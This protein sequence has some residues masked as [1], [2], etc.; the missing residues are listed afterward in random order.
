[1]MDALS[2]ASPLLSALLT[3][4]G[5]VS[6][7]TA[8][9]AVA[10]LALTHPKARLHMW[11]GLL[12]VLLLL[13]V[14]EPWSAPAEQAELTTAGVAA[15]ASFQAA[16]PPRW[17]WSA[18]DWLWALAAGVALRLILVAA[19]FL[20]LRRYRMQATPFAAPPLRFTSNAARWY[21]SDS[22]PGPVT[23]GWRR[24]VILLPAKVLE[25]PADLREAIECHELIHVRRGDWLV[26]LAETL[27]RS[28]L[29]F[30]P[31]IWFVLSRIQLAREQVV[32]CE[33]VG[34]L[35]NRESY[36]NALVAVAGHKLCPNL[37]P[38]P[39]FLRKR[40][41]AARVAAVV[42][43]VDMSRSKILAGVMAAASVVS[44]AAFAAMWMFPFVGQAQTSPDSPG[45]AVDAG[46]TLLH[47]APV[48]VPAGLTAAGTVTVQAT[49]DAKGEVS[50]ARVLSGPDELRREALASVLQW[51][52]QPG[53]AQALVT[54][55]F[56]GGSAAPAPAVAA[57]VES[58]GV[59][60][61][62]RSGPQSNQS[63]PSLAEPGTIESIQFQ[64]VSAEA[65]QELRARLQIREG[66]VVSQADLLTRGGAVRAFDSHL[67]FTY[68]VTR[69]SGSLEYNVQVRVRPDPPAAV[70]A[71]TLAQADA[72][73]PIGALPVIGAAAMSKKLINGPKP[74]YPTIAKSARIQ[75][76]VALQATI[77]TDGTVQ[78][79]TVLSSENPLL[80]PAAVDAVKQWVYEPTL[81]NGNPVP[82]STTVTVNFALQQ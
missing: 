62:G 5:Q 21:A 70:Q 58:I 78:K 12:V 49:L 18:E 46:A 20:R 55:R 3:W 63:Q 16:A 7:L 65:E 64:G 76:T 56:G 15:T 54:I 2:S 9:A 8:A 48:H 28:L 25:L 37:A 75:G 52:Y 51:H 71:P 67:A 13:P 27:L 47:R 80:T 11:Q 26:V 69:S 17:H 57:P 1:M 53:P 59:R 43:E 30:H 36:L 61:G 45:I 19:G 72:S 41:L 23:Y 50:D 29:W 33:A 22:V 44:V 74:V 40:H 77:A 68:S 81:L 24:P 38:A 32:D 42:R 66:D 35:R 73:A 10:A 82:V 31:A 4:S 60:G 14:I 79:L 6:V 39:S 34:L